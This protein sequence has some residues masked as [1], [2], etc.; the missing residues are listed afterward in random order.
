MKGQRFFPITQD[1]DAAH[2]Y[3]RWVCTYRVVYP[4]CWL[5]INTAQ[6]TRVKAY[7]VSGTIIISLYY[8]FDLVVKINK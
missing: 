1:P 7:K 8:T 5:F 6:G 2:R 4:Y 3:L